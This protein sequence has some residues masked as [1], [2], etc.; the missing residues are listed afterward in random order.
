MPMIAANGS[1]ARGLGTLRIA[2][3]AIFLV[4]T[5]PLL[6]LV[7][8]LFRHHGG[9]LFGVPDDSG[10]RAGFYGVL[11]P[12]SVVWGLI[13]LRS[14]FALLFTLGVRA[15]VTGIAAAAAAYLVWSQEPLSFI[16]TYHALLISMV[17]IALGDGADAR[18]LVPTKRAASAARSSVWL[19]RAFVISVYAWSALAKL[20]P[21]WT[22]GE[23]LARLHAHGYTTGAL[24]DFMLA[25]SH[26]ALTAKATLAVELALGPLLAWRRSRPLAIV[27]ASVMHAGFEVTVHPDVFGW[28]M[29][30]LLTVFWPLA[31]DAVES[32]VHASVEPRVHSRA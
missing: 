17:L 16:F 19:L 25:P 9:P 23:T 21:A 4:R 20:G 14:V 7:P 12:T 30:S 6:F 31:R 2:V 22:S 1:T 8:G 32:R 5:T 11:L 10:L 27:M 28:L 26:V 29:V 18:A 3:G 15:R 24:A 13:A